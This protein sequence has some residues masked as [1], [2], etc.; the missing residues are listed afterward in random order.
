[1]RYATSVR[2]I[3][4]A[5]GDV[6]QMLKDLNVD[7]QTLIVFTSDNGPSIE[8][9]VKAPYSPTFFGSYGPFDGIKRDVWEGGL[10]VPTVVRWPGTVAGGG[11]S[12]VP[13]SF[14]D[15]MATFAEA[16]GVPAPA[17]CDGVS[18]LPALTGQGTQRTPRVYVEYFHNAKTPKY[19][20]FE[21]SHR[22][23]VRQQMQTLVIGDHVGVRYDV[24]KASDDFEIY[25]AV[26][27]PKQAHNLAKRPD[28]V[29]LQKQFKETALQVRRPDEGAKR[30]YDDEPVPAV[31]A[32]GGA[33][34]GLNWRAYAGPFPWV[35]QFDALTATGAGR[36]DELKVDAAG[37][38]AG[39]RFDGYIEAPADGRYTFSVAGD[40][41]VVMR[42][43]EATVI[44]ADFG[45]TGGREVS[46]TIVLKA[47][48]HPFHLSYARRSGATADAPALTLQWSGPG[49]E[50]RPV[51]AGAF[52]NEVTGQ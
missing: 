19:D 23:R 30:P 6:L 46:A 4:D 3:D 22:N 20:E 38:A 8:S 32:A 52:S 41:G 40:G 28:M 24:K 50:K 25:D 2:R 26:K 5:V 42:L 43:H 34:P 31:A 9:Y 17:R 51:P 18:L 21:P 27:D 13:S 14:P 37:G 39:V 12:T 15:W 48:R 1:M 35:P 44:D 36:A 45:Y 10:R 47:G 29:G 11:A 33:R 7:D 49:F 16:A